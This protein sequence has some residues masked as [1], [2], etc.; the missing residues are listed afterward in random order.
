MLSGALNE[1][2][3]N[4]FVFVMYLHTFKNQF[5]LQYKS[6]GRI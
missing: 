4:Y 1:L 2:N 6:F 3:L 5:D